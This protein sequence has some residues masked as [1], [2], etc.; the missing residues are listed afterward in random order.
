MQIR[1]RF[2]FYLFKREYQSFPSSFKQSHD[3]AKNKKE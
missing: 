3:Y 2:D 1:N